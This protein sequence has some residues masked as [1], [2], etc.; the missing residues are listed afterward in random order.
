MGAWGY[1]PF[2]NDDAMDWVIA[3]VDSGDPNLPV[4]VLRELDA[5][6]SIGAPEGAV[7]VAAAEAF[8]ASR[9]QPG[10][11]PEDM[12]QWLESTGVHADD[13]TAGIALRV[14]SKIEGGNSELAQLL[15]E[16]D[17]EEWQFIMSD[18]RR[19]LE[20]PSQAEVRPDVS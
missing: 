3:L 20:L 9:G 14:I 10:E 2:D 5:A 12:E 7:G 16:A 15:D 17:D 11:V 8:T 6:I 18:L 19:R 13:V 1:G 4:Q